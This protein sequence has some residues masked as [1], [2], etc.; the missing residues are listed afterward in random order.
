MSIVHG[1]SGLRAF[2]TSRILGYADVGMAGLDTKNMFG[3][4][5]KTESLSRDLFCAECAIVVPDSPIEALGIAG[6]WEFM[7][8]NNHFPAATS[9]AHQGCIR[10]EADS[11]LLYIAP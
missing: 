9:F 8:G 10:W 11:S 7:W 5:A 3:S 1:R 6:I 2:R 4:E